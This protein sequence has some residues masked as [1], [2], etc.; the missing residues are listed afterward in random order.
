[1]DGFGG[2]FTNRK[3]DVSLDLGIAPQR[4]YLKWDDVIHANVVTN[5][6]EWRCIFGIKE[7]LS[8]LAFLPV[9]NTP[10]DDYQLTASAS[11]PEQP[12]VESMIS[13]ELVAQIRTTQF[14]DMLDNG[15]SF[16]TTS[17]DHASV[18]NTSIPTLKL[19]LSSSTTVPPAES[20]I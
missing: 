12:N 10:R 14:D 2:S 17:S 19:T 5:K 3:Y 7:P 16:F 1:M 20:R 13:D 15:F 8:A 18:L 11:I 9:M 4:S 6:A